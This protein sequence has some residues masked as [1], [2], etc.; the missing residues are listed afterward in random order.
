MR[1]SFGAGEG[2]IVDE[3]DDANRMRHLARRILPTALV[4]AFLAWVLFL[5]ILIATGPAEPPG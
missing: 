3:V 4:A 2:V 1:W 5:V